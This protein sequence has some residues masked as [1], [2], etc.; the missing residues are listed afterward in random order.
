MAVGLSWISLDS[1]V[2][3][4]TYQY[5]TREIARKFFSSGF[6]GIEGEKRGDGGRRHAEEQIIHG[7]SLPRFPIFRNGLFRRTLPF[8][9]RRRSV[10]EGTA[11]V[12]KGETQQFARHGR[13]LLLGRLLLV[14]SQLTEAACVN[15]AT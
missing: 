10:G 14:S 3:I 1:L 8:G 11:I 15:V 7:A 13:N 2:R 4:E 5:V 6:I 9:L 12:S